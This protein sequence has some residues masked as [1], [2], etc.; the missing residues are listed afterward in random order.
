[1][2]LAV[3]RLDAKAWGF[4]FKE[5]SLSRILHNGCELPVPDLWVSG[6]GSFGQILFQN[7]AFALPLAQVDELPP[8]NSLALLRTHM[9]TVSCF[10]RSI[11]GPAPLEECSSE[12]LA[13]S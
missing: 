2:A 10:W 7:C 5:R 6:R 8:A 13:G 12:G 11:P 3:S 4:K 1:M 9:A